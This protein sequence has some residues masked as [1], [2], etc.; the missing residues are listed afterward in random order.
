MSADCLF[1]S[2]W[3]R[4]SFCFVFFFFSW[5]TLCAGHCVHCS[6][7]CLVEDLSWLLAVSVAPWGADC[8][9]CKESSYPRPVLPGWLAST[10]LY[11]GLWSPAFSAL[12]ES[13]LK[14]CFSSTTLPMGLAV[15]RLHHSSTCFLPFPSTKVD[16]KKHPAHQISSWSLLSREP[17]RWP[18]VLFSNRF[19]S[20][21]YTLAILSA[22]I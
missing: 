3:V 19:N 1:S 18:F 2:Q 17:N 10:D 12:L 4:V 13:F 7:T 22:N 20:D 14:G 6:D 21:S 15:I 5:W 9:S 8:L 16:L 11:V